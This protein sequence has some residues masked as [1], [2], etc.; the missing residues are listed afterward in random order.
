MTLEEIIVTAVSQHATDIHIEHSK[1]ATII[2]QRCYGVLQKIAELPQDSSLIN[3]IKMRSNLDLSETRRT[4]EG[5]FLFEEKHRSTFIRVSII[6]TVKGEKV[7]MRLLP[8]KSRLALNDIGIQTALLNTLSSTLAYPSGLILVCGA[9]GAGK[10]TSLYSCLDALNTGN[11][12]IFTIEDP[13]EYDIPG[14]FQC[15]PNTAIGLDSAELLKSFLRQD[16]DVIMVGEVRDAVT[17]NLA[18]NAALTGHLVLATLHTNSALDAIH[19]CHGWQVDFFSLVSSL[20]LIIHQSMFY[21]SS[22]QH[23]IFN[24]LQPLWG[25]VLPKDYDTLISTP[26]LWKAFPSQSKET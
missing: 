26:S 5:Q 15:E 20:K 23:P 6:A 25:E 2:Y 18:V 1:L 13:V 22:S 11:K 17:A 10:S 21:K 14:L 4:Q 24:G 8:E 3:R 16:P 7:A 12:T 9:T 19:R